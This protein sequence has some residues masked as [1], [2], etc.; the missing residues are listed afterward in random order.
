MFHSRCFCA[1]ESS[2]IDKALLLP[3]HS[4]QFNDLM[5]FGLLCIL[6]AETLKDA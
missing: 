2:K 3:Y 6:F 1:A 5:D 4:E